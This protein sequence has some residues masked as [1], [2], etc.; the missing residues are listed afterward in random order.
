MRMLLRHLRVRCV[1][2]GAA[3]CVA[4]ALAMLAERSAVAFCRTTTCVGDSCPKDADGCPNTGF[5]LFWTSRCLGLNVNRDGTYQLDKI[6]SALV[7]RRSFLRWSATLCPN[8]DTPSISFTIDPG[9]YTR[10]TDFKDGN[11]NINIVF[12]KDDEWI[13]KGID[14]TIATTS[15]SFDKTSG[16]IWDADLAFNTANEKF[17]YGD[18]STGEKRYDLESVA[19]HEAGHFLGIAH[20]QIAGSVMLYDLAPATIRRELQPDDIDAVCS[21]YPPGRKALCNPQP[22]GGFEDTD[23]PG[24]KSGC[25]SAVAS[26]A[27]PPHS[28]LSAAATGIGMVALLRRRRRSS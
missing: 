17:D 18:E 19:T 9:A 26:S 27:P 21:I 28:L 11:K 16:E 12:F 23:A 20:T 6:A 2:R 14:G 8:G 4:I 1:R 24:P 15:V 7:V 13:Y 10:R 22:K 5:K 25:S 3:C